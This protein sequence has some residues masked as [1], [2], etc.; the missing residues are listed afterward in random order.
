[1]KDQRKDGMSP[2]FTLATDQQIPQMSQRTKESE[3]VNF[4]A[5]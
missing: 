2:S 5:Y 1:M 4:L 3:L